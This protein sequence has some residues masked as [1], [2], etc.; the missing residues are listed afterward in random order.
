[1][2]KAGLP[3]LEINLIKETEDLFIQHCE[4]LLKEIEEDTHKWKDIPC[5]QTG[6]INISNMF[7]LTKAT[8]GFKIA[9]T[10]FTEIEK[11]D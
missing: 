9:M 5:S 1:V 11:I 7:I 10:F 3:Q 8:C 4:T 2:S 6:R